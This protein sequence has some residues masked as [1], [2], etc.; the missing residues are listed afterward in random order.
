M[1]H[2]FAI[3]AML[4]APALAGPADDAAMLLSRFPSGGVPEVPAVLQAIKDIGDAGRDE[5]LPLLAS[6]IEQES[7]KIGNAA[8]L[9]AAR[10]TAD[11]IIASADAVRAAGTTEP[12]SPTRVA[13]EH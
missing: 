3:I 5:D 7:T 12:G 13:D 11:T 2:L 10:I 4:Q 6:L 8:T 9:A 1:F